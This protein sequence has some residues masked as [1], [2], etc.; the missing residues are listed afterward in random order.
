MF[1]FHSLL[2][3]PTIISFK[4]Q[5]SQSAFALFL[6]IFPPGIPSA[7]ELYARSTAKEQSATGEKWRSFATLIETSITR[8]AVRSRW[9]RA[10][11][12]DGK[13]NICHRSSE[14][15]LQTRPIITVALN[16]S[17]RISLIGYVF[18]FSNYFIRDSIDFVCIP[19]YFDI[20]LSA[21]H[22]RYDYLYVRNRV[23][24][25]L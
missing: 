14:F 13:S 11:H 23:Y 2:L 21:I 20:K 18:L 8:I 25:R 22:Y 9:F 12:V 10:R 3:S 4:F 7:C 6:F 24:R 19:N 15:V 17:N 1:L 5:K 16:C